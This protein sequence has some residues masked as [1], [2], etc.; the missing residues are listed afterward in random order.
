MPC[1]A[2][3]S[4]LPVCLELQTRRLIPLRLALTMLTPSV[5]AAWSVQQAYGK[6]RGFGEAMRRAPYVSCVLLIVIATYMAWHG[7]HALVSR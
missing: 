3:F 2:A 5:L 1:P 7:W 4:V 6:F